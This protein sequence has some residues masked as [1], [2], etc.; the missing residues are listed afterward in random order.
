MSARAIVIPSGPQSPQ[1]EV[2]EWELLLNGSAEAGPQGIS[3]AVESLF[4]LDD[5]ARFA[6]QLLLRREFPYPLPRRRGR[7]R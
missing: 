1:G 3:A 7:R 2:G 6:E 4:V 5:A